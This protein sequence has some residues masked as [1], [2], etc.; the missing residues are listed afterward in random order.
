MRIYSRWMWLGLCGLLVLSACDTGATVQTT[1]V[2]I[3]QE[4]ITPV[5][6]VGGATAVGPVVGKATAVPS[7]VEPAT[8]P[9]MDTPELDAYIARWLKQNHASAVSIALIHEGK[10]VLTKGYGVADREKG[11]SADGDTVYLLASVS[12]IIVG[13]SAIK[14]VEDGRLDLDADISD[15]LGYE[16]RNPYFPDEPITM[17]HLLTHTSGL[18]DAGVDEVADYPKPDPDEALGDYIADTLLEDG[19]LYGDADFWSDEYAPGIFSE[20]ANIGATLAAYVVEKVAGEPFTDFTNKTFFAPLG[21]DH[22]R[23]YVRELPADT[24]MA[25][26]YDTNFK[27]YGIYSFNDYPSG[28]LRSSVNDFSQIVLMLANHGEL[29]G[30]RYFEPATLAEFQRV[31]F[32]EVE[33]TT[34][35]HIFVYVDDGGVTSYYHTGGESGSA[36]YVAYDEDGNG[37]IFFSNVDLEEYDELMDRLFEEVYALDE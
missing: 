33:D 15:Y 1:P 28:S 24:H 21:M 20:Y 14:L 8:A 5:T 2:A 10:L 22:T 27:P 6:L 3:V 4:E 26:P 25:M 23:W 35:L 16:L 13:L 18:I 19:A 7:V 12:K 37:A 30:R 17:R 36:T 29:N 34:A 32:P 9:Q 31:Q 11:W